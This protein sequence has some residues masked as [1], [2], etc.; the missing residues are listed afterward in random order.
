MIFF[1]ELEGAEQRGEEH[2]PER[3]ANESATRDGE[4]PGQRGN[5]PHVCEATRESEIASGAR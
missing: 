2:A 5:R 1:E 3:A 4:R